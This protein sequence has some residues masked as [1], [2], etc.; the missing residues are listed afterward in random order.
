MK[1]VCL[2][3]EAE[4]IMESMNAE[5]RAAVMAGHRALHERLA[6][7]GIEWSGL[8]LLPTS[9]AVSIRGRSG[10]PEVTDGPFAETTEQLAGFYAL[11]CETLEQAVEY[12]KLLPEVAYG[13]IEVRSE[14]DLT[15]P[16]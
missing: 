10:A 3:Y 6:K 15:G 5:E 14:A 1:F 2:I 7:D 8:P 13:T 12:A 11:E 4:E 16:G 9:S